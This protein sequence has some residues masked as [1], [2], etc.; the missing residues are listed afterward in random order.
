MVIYSN[1]FN[2]VSS[3]SLDLRHLAEATEK[4]S[5][6]VNQCLGPMENQKAKTGQTLFKAGVFGR[7]R[8]LQDLL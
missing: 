4:T 7:G 2:L 8:S 6:K 5:F 3:P 1:T